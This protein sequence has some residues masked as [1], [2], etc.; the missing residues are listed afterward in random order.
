MYPKDLVDMTKMAPSK[1]VADINKGIKDRD[2]KIVAL[3][4]KIAELEATLNAALKPETKNDEEIAKLEASLT[5]VKKEAA[6]NKDKKKDAELKAK[7][8]KWTAKLKE[9][10]DKFKEK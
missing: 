5:A 1:S 9:A 3:Q 8:E 10:K 2:E 4:A 7:V 6:D